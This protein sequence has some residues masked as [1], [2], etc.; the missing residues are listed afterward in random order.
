MS[1]SVYLK[2]DYEELYALN[3]AKNKPNSKP[4]CRPLGGTNPSHPHPD[5]RQSG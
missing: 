4:I 5:A 1:L 3:A 2:G